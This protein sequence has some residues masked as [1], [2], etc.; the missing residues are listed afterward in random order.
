MAFDPPLQVFRQD[1][2]LATTFARSQSSIADCLIKG[3][4]TGAGHRAGLGYAQRKW[5]LF[6]CVL[7]CT[8]KRFGE[9]VRFNADS[10]ALMLADR[11]D[12]GF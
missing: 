9:Y 10:E 12:K 8:P 2:G 11:T 1:Q 3:S 5:E 4:A 7:L 6:Q